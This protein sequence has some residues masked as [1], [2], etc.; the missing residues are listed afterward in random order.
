MI[1]A[2]EER[3]NQLARADSHNKALE[4]VFAANLD[5]LVV[6]SALAMPELKT[7]LIDRYLLI[8]HHN[9][10]EPVVVLNPADIVR[11]TRSLPTSTTLL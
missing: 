7:G 8:A 3:R 2:I 5:R 10:I 1:V 4:H 6:V 11:A 9:E